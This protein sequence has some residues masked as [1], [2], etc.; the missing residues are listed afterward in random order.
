MLHENII[1]FFVSFSI[2]RL[3]DV[4]LKV[5]PLGLLLFNNVMVVVSSSRRKIPVILRVLDNKS[6]GLAMG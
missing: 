3:T 2:Y 6:H 5:F 4:M 1:Y